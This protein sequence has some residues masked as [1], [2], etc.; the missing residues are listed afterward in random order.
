MY[1]QQLFLF[2]AF[3]NVVISYPVSSGEVKAMEPNNPGAA[4]GTPEG[5]PGANNSG[6]NSNSNNAS[7][8]NGGAATQ[9]QGTNGNSNQPASQDRP[10]A[11]TIMSAVDAF[12][13]DANTVSAQ[14]NALPGLMNELD[15]KS[16][17]K[18][19]LDAENDE[20]PIVKLLATTAGNGGL[21]AN[22]RLM[23]YGPTVVAG[24]MDMANKGT[25]ESVKTN[26]AMIEE[27]RNPNVLP[28]IT[29]LSNAALDSMGITT[30]VAQKFPV[31]G[32]NR[33]ARV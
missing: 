30:K 18:A 3:T 10:S 19:A 31:T 17:A 4:G 5:V 20:G 2:L 9:G 21:A 15:I 28:S 14:M 25:V 22:T 16:A 29:E 12:A 6:N 26:I 32:S 23:K 27:V 7:N 24:L 11:D 13:K 33:P 8:G 1:F